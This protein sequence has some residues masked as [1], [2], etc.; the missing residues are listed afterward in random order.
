MTVSEVRKK[1]LEFF[2][3]KGHTIVPSSLLVPENDPT[4]LFTGS[5]MQPMVPY[6]LGEKHPSGRRI[7]DSQ[8]CFRSQDIE[9][10]G[11][12]R[13]TTFF[14]M[15]GN[16]SLGDYWK[17]EQLSWV[18]AFLTSEIG[19]P[20]EKL[21]VTCFEGDEKLGIP[22]DTESAEIWERLG[23]P[24]DHIH[25]Y[26]AK[27]NWWSRAGV[28]ENMPV[29]EPGG[30]DSEIFY[31]FSGIAHNSAFG[32]RCHP[33]CDCGRFMEI[34][35]SVFME[36]R[37]I[38]PAEDGSAPFTKGRIGHSEFEKLPQRNVDFGGGLERIT[39]ARNDSSD[40][41]TID[42]FA[43][44]IQKLAQLS[45]KNYTDPAYTG[46]FRT[47]A[48]HL[49]ASV[50][51]IADGASPSNTDQGYFT[52]RLLRRA[53]RHLDLLGIGADTLSSLVKPVVSAYADAYPS[54]LQ[55][56]EAITSEIGNEE[57]KFRKTLDMGLKEFSRMAEKSLDKTL[58]GAN[59]FMLFSSYGL[60]ID[61][62]KD[63]APEKGLTV[64]IAGFEKELE[65]HHVIS[66]AG[67]EKKF[68]GGLA[69]TSEESLKYHTATHLLHQALRDVL[70]DEVGQKG[71]NITPERL[72]FDFS[73]GRKMTDDEKKKVED[74]VNAKIQ[75]K[76]PM[77]R[78]VM[79]RAEAEKSG[80][81]HFFGEK[82]SDEVSIYFIGDT[83]ETA[84]SREFCGGPHVTN[85]GVLGTFKIQKE[86]AV[87]AGVRRIK[88]VLEK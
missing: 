41:F 24:K 72:R 71:S 66:R 10:V 14:E 59:A 84:Y 9:E 21:S 38:P 74:I 20:K 70:G 48:E 37:K 27:K 12:N 40:V 62:I 87:S 16:W 53:V 5:G 55:K 47:V 15:L 43:P 51:L 34:G 67:I 33:N 80:A 39:A 83:L 61:M 13:H 81:L 52:R 63:L 6:L 60:P 49:R 76:L 56:S 2:K 25:F 79:P 31:E 78:V 50:F 26:S 82:Y 69:D 35:N 88:A 36:Y 18:F 45:E 42:V 64:D 85:T 1:Y 54:L 32:E 75:A 77:Q 4:T 65:N 86:E 17:E 58:S 44:L 73:F 28:P 19:I 46:S 7:A 57:H 68:K 8:K 3:S 30:A 11:D 23:I 22:R 29:G